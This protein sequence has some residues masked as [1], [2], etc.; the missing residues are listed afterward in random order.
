MKQIIPELYFKVK[1]FDFITMEEQRFHNARNPL[2]LY[3]PIIQNNTHIFNN[4]TCAK[5]FSNFMNR[6]VLRAST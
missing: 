4:E 6:T 1:Y 5:L 3:S 2:S